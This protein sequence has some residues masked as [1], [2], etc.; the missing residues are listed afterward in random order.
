[1]PEATPNAAVLGVR[2]R[3]EGERARPVVG[4]RGE[5]EE[6]DRSRTPKRLERPVGAPSVA[7]VRRRSTSGSSVTSAYRDQ[8]EQQRIGAGWSDA[9][10]TTATSQRAGAALQRL[11]SDVL[12]R[13]VEPS[14]VSVSAPETPRTAIARAVQGRP[15]PPDERRHDEHGDDRWAARQKRPREECAACAATVLRRA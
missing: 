15:T 2:E 13:A 4:D 9:V 10:A 1:M 7:T 5:R 11:G 14:T 12:A 8:R 3:G 6:A